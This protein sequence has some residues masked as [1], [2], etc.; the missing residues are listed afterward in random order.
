MPESWPLTNGTLYGCGALTWPEII[1]LL[2]GFVGVWGDVDGMHLAEPLP[3]EAPAYTHVWAW[4]DETYA[5][6]RLDLPS[7]RHI[8]GMLAEDGAAM[9]S[10]PTPIPPE[11]VTATVYPVV[12][13]GTNTRVK[14]LAE[15]FREPSLE[16]LVT[17]Q[18]APVTF[19]RPAGGTG[20]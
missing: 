18:T 1:R 16:R 6:V 3:A 19:V 4:R 12:G 15:R 5:R 13:W 7:D 2:D 8:L 14:S 11:E 10:V 9:P 20:T 17:L